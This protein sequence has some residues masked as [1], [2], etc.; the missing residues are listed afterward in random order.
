[1]HETNQEFLNSKIYFLSIYIYF[2]ENTYEA[3]HT[4][5]KKLIVILLNSFSAVATQVLLLI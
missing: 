4:V 2:V 3:S 1:M 5:S